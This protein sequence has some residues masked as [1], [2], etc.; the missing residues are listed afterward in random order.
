MQLGHLL[1]RHPI[2]TTSVVVVG[3]LYICVGN[4]GV[5]EAVTYT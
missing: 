1:I 5:V 3:C 4:M 2:M